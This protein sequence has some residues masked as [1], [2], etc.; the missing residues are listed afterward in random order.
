MDPLQPYL[1][2]LGIERGLSPRTVTA[3]GRDIRDFLATAV[4][5]GL[6]EEPAGRDQWPRLAGQRD[7]IR[8][9]LAA[10]RRRGCRPSTLDR[11]LAAI[12]SFYRYLKLTSQVEDVPGNLGIG[13]GGR[14]RELP[15]DLNV[16]L[17]AQLLEMPDSATPRG[18]R[19][20]ALLEVIYGLGLRLAEVTGL[21][22]GDLDFPEQ[23]VRVLGKGNR[24]RVLPLAGCAADALAVHLAGSLEPG[25][26]QDVR[27]GAAGRTAA[28][29]PVFEGRPGRRIGRRTVQALVA[30][31]AGELAQVAGVSPHT[32]RHSFATHLLDGGA[33]I[34]VVQELLGHRHLSTTQIYTH[35]G[36]SRLRA[37]FEAAHPR[38][39]TRRGG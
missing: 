1:D 13:R 34:R 18:R 23:R 36:R 12:R 29:L 16:E 33:G 10:L 32:L 37:S 9:H 35:L 7:L 30:R 2:H 31:Y 20:R 21:D 6:V 8:T 38:A 39:R 22:L 17:T 27:D 25:L 19:D 24:E 26:W 11:H 15:H 14:R 3:Y 28:A 5:S 4:A